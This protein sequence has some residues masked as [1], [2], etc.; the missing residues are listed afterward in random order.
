MP[1]TSEPV[2]SWIADL[3]GK[4]GG[5]AAFL[6]FLYFGGRSFMTLARDFS[7][8]V[9]AELQSIRTAITGQ[10]SR[11]DGLSAEIR[12]LSDKFDNHIRQNKP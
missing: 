8:S 7:T 10:N 2:V 11:V 12:S 9:T 3:V 1:T 6:V 5:W 4:G